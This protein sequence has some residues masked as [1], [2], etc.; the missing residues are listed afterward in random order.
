MGI[1]VV[2]WLRD[3]FYEGQ[4]LLIISIDVHMAI[5]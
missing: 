5:A 2:K 1:G 3:E 4:I